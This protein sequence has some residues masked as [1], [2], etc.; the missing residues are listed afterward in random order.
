MTGSSPPACPAP[1]VWRDFAALKIDSLAEEELLNHLSDCPDCEALLTEIDS[2]EPKG[3]FLQFVQ[4]AYPVADEPPPAR[5]R[6]DWASWL[7]RRSEP[8]DPP[9]QIDEYHLVGELGRGAMGVVYQARHSTLGKF[10]AIKLLR[11]QHAS[12]FR[13]EALAVGRLDHPHI[14]AASDARQCMG[15][16]ILV[17]EYVEGLN[18]QTLVEQ[19]GPLPASWACEIMRQAALGLQHIHQ[20]GL[21]H[22]DIKPKNLMLSRQGQIKILDFGLALSRE[23]RAAPPKELAGTLD[24]VSPEN[25]FGDRPL[26]I[27]TDIYSL[28][29][30]FYMLLSG[31]PPFAEQTGTLAKMR[32]HQTTPPP[33][34]PETT[35]PQVAEVMRRMLAKDPDERYK[36][37]QDI[38]QA[39][40]PLREP[41][42]SPCLKRT[43]TE[44]PGPQP[45][46]RPIYSSHS[47]WRGK[48]ILVWSLPAVL[49]AVAVIA[50]IGR[51][52]QNPVAPADRLRLEPILWPHEQ[53]TAH[54]KPLED[55][56]LQTHCKDLGLL[57]I[58]PVSAQNCVLEVQFEQLHPSGGMGVFFD[59]HDP[60]G[61]LKALFCGIVL[62]KDSQG[63][64]RVHRRP[65]ASPGG[66][67]FS[68]GN[69]RA[70]KVD[71]QGK[72]EGLRL[73]IR[74]GILHRVV[75]IDRFGAEQ[76]LPEVLPTT[77]LKSRG[78]IGLLVL[79]AQGVFRQVRVDG[80]P[81]ELSSTAW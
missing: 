5:P 37:P 57:A 41:D 42:L 28:G 45:R 62:E 64:F 61:R 17:M 56:G 59:Y 58:R 71:Y 76:A 23:S 2:Q 15:V 69:G 65:A 77:P 67:S 18:L 68:I 40:E 49:M 46:G 36:T 73:E 60:D 51:P 12:R 80:V 4:A 16:P 55:G 52:P 30:T 75:Y 9:R 22:R 34:L 8:P 7:W 32:A 39:L 81:V 3:S 13:Q 11:P 54:I 47:Y 63:V 50:V 1:Q 26:D 48:A 70:A 43:E 24:Y 6:R 72:G 25:I 29:C 31:Q 19:V 66:G 38:A 10:V 35:P 20:Q 33:P 53:A 44:R 21:V 74:N 79:E 14:A 78:S 27:R